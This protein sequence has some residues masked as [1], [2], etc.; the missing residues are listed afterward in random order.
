MSSSLCGNI[1]VSYA[2]KLQVRII[3]LQKK[4]VIE[5]TENISGSFIWGVLRGESSGSFD[6]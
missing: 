3:F 4:I 1:L 2:K 6:K 5:L